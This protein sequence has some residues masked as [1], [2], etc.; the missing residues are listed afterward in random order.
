MGCSCDMNIRRGGRVVITGFSANPSNNVERIADFEAGGFVDVLCILDFQVR[1]G[2]SFNF[3]V[4]AGISRSDFDRCVPVVRVV[5]EYWAHVG[6]SHSPRVRAFVAANS[7]RLA[8]SQNPPVDLAL[9]F[10][11]E[12][13]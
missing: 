13:G 8:E 9:G 6:L 4:R 5:G 7:A 2:S 12:G 1:A 11:V 10:Q 3:E